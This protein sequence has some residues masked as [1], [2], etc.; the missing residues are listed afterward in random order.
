MF[1]MEDTSLNSVKALIFD[2][3]GVVVDIDFNNVFLRWAEYSN[4]SVKDI[5]SRFSF[6]HDYEAHERGEIDSADYFNSLRKTLGI[7]ISDQQFEDGWN[8]IFNG[9]IP[10]ISRL[11]QRAREELPI[12]AFTNSNR[13]HQKEWSQRFSEILSLFD[14]V[15]S[16][17]EIGKRKPEPEAFQIVADS[18]GLEF[19][20]MI[21]YDDSMNN[22]IGARKVG[23]KTVHVKSVLDIADSFKDIF[24]S[25]RRAP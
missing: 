18:I 23:L 7:D 9:K 2:L 3:G 17:S 6:D 12:Y 5:Q 20:Q 8:S 24:G 13:V 4:R 21:F 19:H 11:L 14:I 25:N 15:F 22:I 1:F 16:S 10:G